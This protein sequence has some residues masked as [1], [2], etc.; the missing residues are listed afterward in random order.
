MKIFD[1]VVEKELYFLNQR[2]ENSSD[3]YKD[4][5]LWAVGAVTAG[6]LPL[7]EIKSEL[8]KRIK[9]LDAVKASGATEVY[10]EI[11]AKAVPKPLKEEV[12]SEE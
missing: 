10:V 5:L 7:Y 9:A 6:E 3:K 11:L 2:H 1:S 4:I 12:A 8:K